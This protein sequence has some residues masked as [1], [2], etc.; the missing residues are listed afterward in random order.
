[1]KRRFTSLDRQTELDCEYHLPDRYRD[2][3]SI[4]GA[5]KLITQGAGVSYVGAS[6]SDQSNVIGM[7]K[8][9]RILDFSEAEKWIE[10]EAGISLG[11]LFNFLT[12]KNL[13]LPVMP[14]HPQISVG[15]CIAAN[16]HGKN[17]FRE[18]TFKD[19]VAAISLFHPDQGVLRLSRNENSEIFD[20]TCG[21][22][23]L[24]GIIL[25]ARLSIVAE[26]ATS[27]NQTTQSVGSLEDA[28]NEVWRAKD[29]HDMIYG[30]LDMS[31]CNVERGFIVMGDKTKATTN[32]ESS[33]FSPF[34]PEVSSLRRVPVFNKYTMPLINYWY[35]RS[36]QTGDVPTV[37]SR[38]D[39]L[40]PAASKSYYFDLYGSKGFIEAQ[41]LVPANNIQNYCTKFRQ[42][43]KEHAPTI[44]LATVKASGG[45][46]TLLNYAGPGLSFALDLPATS[47][48][49]KFLSAL[50]QINTEHGCI[51]SI[52]KDSRLSKETVDAQYA[53]ST[54]FRDRLKA[55]DPARRFS[56]TISE[57]LGL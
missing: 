12:P 21:G 43:F 18:G 42:L 36:N 4:S 14:G 10:V 32:T 34:A 33:D 19:H 45:K 9:N 46:Q 1:M 47:H 13:S 50:D 16:V 28:F 5:D 11:K 57:R 56:S 30:W 53:E 44:S 52:M 6:F 48:S 15:G 54:E 51:S 31:Q 29:E 41:M 20:L 38:F 17:H 22:L 3:L 40:F 37:V 35:D 27:I 23:G 25:S 49:K 8:F 7:R 55:F 24:T 2:V 26:A 39:F